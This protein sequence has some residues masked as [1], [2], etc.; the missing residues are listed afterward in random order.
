MD[1]RYQVSNERHLIYRPTKRCKT[2]CHFLWKIGE[3]H[4]NIVLNLINKASPKID[5]I[6]INALII[7]QEP[8]IV[9]CLANQTHYSFCNNGNINKRSLPKHHLQPI[10]NKITT[11]EHLVYPFF[12]PTFKILYKIIEGCFSNL[13]F[14]C[15]IS[16]CGKRNNCRFEGW[17]VNYFKNLKLV[18][19]D[20]T[21]SMASIFPCKM[22]LVMLNLIR[23][24][25]PWKIIT[26]I[27]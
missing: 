24:D 8:W 11:V 15:N 1:K 9:C 2:I 14:A 26:L 5:W 16:L 27:I 12:S 20:K 6:F 7:T 18:Y 25:A 19:I 3:G 23:I 13:I 10:R 22:L 21:Y 4:K 17:L